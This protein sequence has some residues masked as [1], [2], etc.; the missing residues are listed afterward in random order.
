MKIS[1][2]ISKT[3]YDKNHNNIHGKDHK[4]V[5]IEEEHE[6]GSTIFFELEEEE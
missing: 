1:E 4:K 2:I 3:D 5:E 6:R